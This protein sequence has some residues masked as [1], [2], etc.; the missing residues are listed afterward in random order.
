M[1]NVCIIAFFALLMSCSPGD[2]IDSRMQHIK[3][4]GDTNPTIALQMLDSLKTLIRDED[5][6]RR[7]LYDLLEIRLKDK[8]YITATTDM[9]IKPLVKYFEKYGSVRERQE[10]YYYA[11]SIY[12]DMRDTPRSVEFFR[13]SADVAETDASH[14]TLMHR[15]AYS[16]LYS[17]YFSVQDYRNA[18]SAA[19]KEYEISL[20]N[21]S[22]HSITLLHLGMSYVRADSTEQ[23]RQTLHKALEHYEKYEKNT[24]NR[25]LL[26]FLLQEM[27]Y[28]KMKESEKCRQ[29]MEESSSDIM[30][31]QEYISLAGY[32]QYAGMQD[33]AIICY[34]RIIED[35]SN[36]AAVYDASRYL[37]HIYNQKGDNATASRYAG[38]NIAASEQLDLGKRQEQAATV[39]NRY[40]YIKDKEAEERIKL[41]DR[42]KSR[43][44]FIIGLLALAASIGYIL[45]HLYIRRKHAREKLSLDKRLNDIRE[46]NCVLR[47]ELESAMNSVTENQV[48]LVKSREEL[49]KI[50]HELSRNE[51]EL[52]IKER[53][54]A[55]R[56]EQNRNYIRL[57][58]QTKLEKSAEDIIDEVREAAKGKATFSS[59]EWRRLYKAVDEIFPDF[60]ETLSHQPGKMNEQTIQVCYLMRIG[61]SNPQIQNVTGL[62]RATIWRWTKR[63][64]IIM[65]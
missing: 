21:G 53:Q 10:A 7:M 37:F 9:H 2:S 60:N 41:E 6:H 4:T 34:E 13:K 31:I 65:S 17:L 3:E 23:A 48:A 51:Y 38:I 46:Q 62:P 63:H 43:T 15:N 29:L 39:N 18:L 11:G 28:M 58:H 64:E 20:S 16:N 49:E 8:A 22:L 42:I 1:R 14:D 36:M 50:N 59:A 30:N 54:L 26:A 32:Y 33:S 57:L 52:S 56:T 12:R 40:N 27:S 19:K 24:A 61:L 47:A 55:E 45:S 5:E 25:H 44:I 35:G